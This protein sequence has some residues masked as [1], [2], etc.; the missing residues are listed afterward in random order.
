MVVASEFKPPQIDSHLE[1]GQAAAHHEEREEEDRIRDGDRGRD[2][3]QQPA[4][5]GRE[6]GDDAGLVADA[7]DDPSRGQGHDEVRAEETEL[8]QQGEEVGEMEEV[9]EVGDKDVV[10]RR[11]EADAEVQRHHEHHGKRVAGRAVNANRCVV[12]SCGSNSH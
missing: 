1:Q 2:E 9:L 8:H 3:E 10:E 12:L 4:A 7:A 11:N 6:R 5:H